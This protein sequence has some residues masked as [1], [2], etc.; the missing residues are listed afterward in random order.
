[1]EA[2]S[3]ENIWIN[4]KQ[5]QSNYYFHFT[6]NMIFL[7]G[8]VSAL[9]AKKKNESLDSSSL[10]PILSVAEIGSMATSLERE[11]HSS[12]RQQVCDGAAWFCLERFESNNIL[13]QSRKESLQVIF[14]SS[15]KYPSGMV[16]MF[17]DHIHHRGEQGGDL[18]QGLALIPYLLPTSFHHLV[19]EWWCD[20]DI[21][22]DLYFLA[23]HLICL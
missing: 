3:L 11:I 12:S 1:M 13:A 16:L 18:V 9:A 23:L 10:G 17:T 14:I 5:W 22:S 8:S 7:V 21:N 4:S 15:E 19:T 20:Y 2:S 6:D